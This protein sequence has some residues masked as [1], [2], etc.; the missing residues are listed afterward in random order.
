MTPAGI[1]GFRG[2]SGAELIQILKRHPH[3]EPVLLEH[4]E[5]E[6]RPRPLGYSGPRRI[7]FSPESV[8]AAGLQAVF[9]ATPPDVS[10]NF[11]GWMLDAGIKVID[12][13]GA[14]RLGTAAN[15]QRWYQESHTAEALLPE[16]V[17]GLPEFCRARIATA[18]LLS[19]PGCYPTAANLA[20]KPLVAAGA[21][22]RTHGIV[23][24][25]KSGVSGAGR[26]PSLKTSFCE[27][28][29]NFSAYSILDHRHVPEVLN[30]S[31]IEENEFSFTAQLIPVDRGILETIYFR[32]AE[33]IGSADDLISIYQQQYS[34]EPFVRIYP[35]GQVPDLHA[36]AHTNFCDIGLKYDARTRRAVVV[37]AIDN[38]GKGAAGQAVQNFNLMMGYPETAGLL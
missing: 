38:L 22:D 16:A 20:L 2:Y 33:N 7:E 34:K 5:A 23:C 19:N 14:F 35:S 6:D 15:Y 31:G 29:E 25:A 11:A 28:T 30:T 17:Y 24:D 8:K 37:S 10:M 26:K 12:L 9:L 13:S 18:R 1:L 21:I 32:T 4:R 27:V 3:A 36:V